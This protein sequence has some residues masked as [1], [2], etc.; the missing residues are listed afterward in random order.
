[1][2][3][4]QKLPTRMDQLRI[5]AQACIDRFVDPPRCYVIYRGMQPDEHLDGRFLELLIPVSTFHFVFAG[6]LSSKFS[7]SHRH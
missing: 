5:V 3:I 7:R 6:L 1:M 2:L 4:A